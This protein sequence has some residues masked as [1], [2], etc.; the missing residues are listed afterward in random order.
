MPPC[1]SP[2]TYPFELHSIRRYFRNNLSWQ[3]KF[4]NIKFQ[5]YLFRKLMFTIFAAVM[6]FPENQ[7]ND[8]VFHTVGK[9]AIFTAARRTHRFV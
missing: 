9:L 3:E 7:E 5:K 8:P 4:S 1:W 2:R 6:F